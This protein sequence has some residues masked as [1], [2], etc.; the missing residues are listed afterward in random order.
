MY[1]SRYPERACPDTN[2]QNG[3][4]RLFQGD[5]DVKSEADLLTC[6]V[7][8]ET[9][10]TLDYGDIDEE[11][12]DALLED[13]VRRSKSAR[14]SVQEQDAFRKRFKKIMGFRRKGIGWGFMMA[15]VT[16]ITV[17]LK[18]SSHILES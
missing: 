5:R 18:M 11:F 13:M 1:A 2:G 14:P 6:F 7:N 16:S 12:Y 3:R 15:S 4:S 9:S 8:A 17:R 10:S